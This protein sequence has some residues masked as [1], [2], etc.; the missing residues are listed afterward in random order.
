MGDAG[1]DGNA[2]IGGDEGDNNNNQD[3]RNRYAYIDADQSLYKGSPLTVT[4]SMLLIST[5]LI[6]HQ[7]TM[8]CIGDIIN[9]INLHCPNQDLKENSIFKFKK[10]FS[11][12]NDNI[13][14][15]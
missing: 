15:H 7:L 9:V 6:K 14:K 4:H 2:D 5:I 13:K 3:R 8:T 10:F 1:S 12:D 11:L